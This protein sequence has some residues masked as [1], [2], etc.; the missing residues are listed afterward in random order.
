MDKDVYTKD[1]QTI[2]ENSCGVILQELY[3]LLINEKFEKV[4]AVACLT[5]CLILVIKNLEIN[6]TANGVPTT[7]TEILNELQKM[8]T[9]FEGVEFEKIEG[10]Q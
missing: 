2:T 6:L 7:V 4:P 3:E 9:F 10:S 1:M 8:N 5:S